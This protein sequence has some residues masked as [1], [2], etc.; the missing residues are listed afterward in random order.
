MNRKA[1][2]VLCILASPVAMGLIAWYV[3]DTPNRRLIAA[4]KVGDNSLAERLLA[5]RR[6]DFKRLDYFGR[7]ALLQAMASDNKPIFTRLLERGANPNLCAGPGICVM[8]DG[9]RAADAFWLRE[10]LAHGGDPNAPNTGNRYYPGWTPVFYAVNDKRNE[11][12]KLLI[13]AGADINRQDGHGEVLLR[14]ARYSGTLE[15]TVLLLE[16][17]ADPSQKDSGGYD[18]VDGL[19]ELDES[20]VLKRNIPWFR[21]ARAILIKRDLLKPTPEEIEALQQGDP[22]DENT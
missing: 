16:A 19:K 21:K 17:G 15:A 14:F 18:F 4:I 20:L 1:L 22:D 3:N 12:V 2:L 13:A 9:A 5:E 8:N 7:T 11:N 10:A 6:Y